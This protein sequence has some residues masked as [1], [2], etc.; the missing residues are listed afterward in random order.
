MT[1]HR[2]IKQ[3]DITA[4]SKAT[5]TTSPGSY[6]L[7]ELLLG[8]ILSDYS[9]GVSFH[10]V[11]DLADSKFSSITI[12]QSLADPFM[13]MAI[14]VNDAT[15][16]LERLG[17]KGLQ[18][19]EFVKIKLYSR[20]RDPIDL[21]FHVAAITPVISDDHQKTNFFNLIC[22]TKE[23]LINDISNVNKFFSGTAADAAE[24][25]WNKNIVGHE[26]YKMLKG[27]KGIKWDDRPFFNSSSVGTE[28]FIVPGLQVN[29]AMKW[30]TT[31]AYGGPEYPGSLYFFFENSA[32]F[33]F[34][35]I[36]NYIETY[37]MISFA[38]RK[39]TYNPQQNSISPQGISQIQSIQNISGLTLP[40]TSARLKN[41]MFSHTVRAINL[42]DKTTTDTNFNMEEKYDSFFVPGNIFGTSTTY[43]NEVAK[44]SP[45]EYLATK[46]STHKDSNIEKILGVRE[47]YSDLLNSYRI[48]ITVYGDSELNVGDFVDL[49]LVESGT[50]GDRDLSIYSG[51]WLVQAV[52]HVCDNEKFNTTLS[53]SKGGLDHIQTKQ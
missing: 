31:K 18:G 44:H 8:K 40:N 5:D 37:K 28:R 17:T 45:Y 20:G 26:K 25:I 48:S 9:G 53:L 22:T 27:I 21:L 4:D 36:E 1:D 49:D 19:E 10:Q 32:G 14:G 11:V 3:K 35:N 6:V 29:Q 15:Q 34:C 39:F 50:S 51:A 41:G 2:G 13:T 47:A 12:T 38:G 16:I 7:D 30:L 46:D 52:S 33:H 23:K 43:F 42:V 24:A